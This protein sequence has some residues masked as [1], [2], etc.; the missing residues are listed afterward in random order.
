MALYTLRF[1]D[2]NQAKQAAQA[3]GFWDEDIDQLRTLGNS[4]NAQDGTV[5]GWSISEIGQDPIVDGEVLHGYYV[6]VDG[7]FKE[8]YRPLLAPEGYGCA[9]VVFAGT[10]P[11]PHNL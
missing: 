11:G 8:E 4:I 6:N 10:E 2:Y 1:A 9:G 3:L 5:F 7:E